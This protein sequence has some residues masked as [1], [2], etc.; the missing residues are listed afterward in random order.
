[1]IYFAAYKKHVGLYPAPRGIDKFKKG[2]SIYGSGNG[3]LRFPLDKP[4]P[5]DLISKIVKFRAK[6][7]LAGGKKSRATQ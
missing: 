4:I 2:L 7:I 3:T 5:F 1:L 6:Q